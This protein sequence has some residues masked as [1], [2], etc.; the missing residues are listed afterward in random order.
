M[1]CLGFHTEYLTGI[2]T[3]A[4][5]RDH[6]RHVPHRFPAGDRQWTFNGDA[7]C[8]GVSS[9]TAVQPDAPHSQA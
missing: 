8:P 7:Y 3:G 9:A 5:L 6:G 1:L 2:P 4:G